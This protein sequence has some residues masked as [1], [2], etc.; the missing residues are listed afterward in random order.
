MP[1]IRRAIGW[2]S[3]TIV[4]PSSSQM[5][6]FLLFARGR[7]LP[8]ITAS[9]CISR[10]ERR[11]HAKRARKTRCSVPRRPRRVSGSSPSP[12]AVEPARSQQTINTCARRS[13]PRSRWRAYGCG[14]I[15]RSADRSGVRVESPM[16]SVGTCTR[17]AQPTW[18]R[19]S[20]RDGRAISL[21]V[22]SQP[23]LQNRRSQV[24]AL[25]PLFAGSESRR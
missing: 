25:S 3:C 21:P 20:E 19:D 5:T 11:E 13:R 17:R 12:S 16:P 7:G 9:P 8:H 18:E 22:C 2:A 4:R 1:G 15:A 24:R 6:A 14:A 23:G 10:S